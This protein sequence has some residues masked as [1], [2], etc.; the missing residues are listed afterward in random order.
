MILKLY[1]NVIFEY[2]WIFKSKLSLEFWKKYRFRKFWKYRKKRWIFEIWQIAFWIFIN[3]QLQ[4][5]IMTKFNF[6]FR[7]FKKISN[8]Y[9]N[10][11]VIFEPKLK[12]NLEILYKNC[13]LTLSRK[14]TN[15]IIQKTFRHLQNFWK[16]FQVFVVCN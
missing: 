9:C 2:Y 8:S 3:L 12:S 14:V 10:K 1:K 5:W 7:I 6:E 16:F 13:L 15:K 11:M 4:L